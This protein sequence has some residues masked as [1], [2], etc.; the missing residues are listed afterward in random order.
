MSLEAEIFTALKGL[1][2]NR[3]YPMILPQSQTVPITP[4][5]RYQFISSEINADVCG[6]GGDGTANTRT[7]VDVY[8]V[9]YVTS[10][11]LRLQVI[12]AM[13]GMPKPTTWEGGFDDYEP[14]LKLYRC[15]MDFVTFPSSA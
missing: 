3:V 13:T 4:A 10:R 1:V 9:D 7:Q 15:S 14:D 2:S 5:I 12:Q 11:N 8:S 6:D